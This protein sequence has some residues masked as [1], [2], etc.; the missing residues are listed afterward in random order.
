MLKDINKNVSGKYTQTL[1]DHVKQSAKDA[2]RTVL[3]RTIQKTVETTGDLIGNKL[4]NNRSQ[5]VHHRIT[6]RIDSETK[7]HRIW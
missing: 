1:F 5:G 2:F 3:K 7:K 6:W 4:T